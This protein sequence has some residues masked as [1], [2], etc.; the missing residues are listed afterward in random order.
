MQ[1]SFNERGNLLAHIWYVII[2]IAVNT[3]NKSTE[4]HWLDGLDTK[5]ICRPFA[6]MNSMTRKLAE[7]EV[8]SN[9]WVLTWGGIFCRRGS[10]WAFRKCIGTRKAYVHSKCIF[11]RHFIQHGNSKLMYVRRTESLREISQISIQ[12]THHQANHRLLTW[13]LVLSFSSQ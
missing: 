7:C 1:C 3:K 9:N 5:C 11:V 4:I 6:L 10:D 13:S 12:F 8:Y 2:D